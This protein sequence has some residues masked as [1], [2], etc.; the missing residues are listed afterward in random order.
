MHHCCNCDTSVDRMICAC[1]KVTTPRVKQDALLVSITSRNISRFS[2]TFWVEFK[3]FRYE[4]PPVLWL[5]CVWSRALLR[6]RV[7]SWRISICY[8]LRFYSAKKRFV[9]L[10][11]I[12][13]ELRT[14]VYFWFVGGIAEG[15]TKVCCGMRAVTRSLWEQVFKPAVGR[16]CLMPW[17]F[18]TSVSLIMFRLQ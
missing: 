6:A 18:V 7:R 8:I 13:T 16:Q 5:E 10:S 15:D 2:R 14:E 3:D 1:Y 17:L 11:D 12:Y 4:W 9:L